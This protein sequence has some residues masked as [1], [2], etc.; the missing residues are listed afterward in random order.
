MNEVTNR[1][2]AYSVRTYNIIDMGLTFSAMIRL[3]SKGSKE[4]I[5]EKIVEDIAKVF[6]VDSKQEYDEVHASFCLWGNKNIVL[7]KRERNGKIIKKAGPAS[8]GQ[9]AKTFDVV[10]KVAIYYSHLPECESAQKIA[11]YLNA[12]LDD[13]MMN[14]LK[15]HYPND[16]NPWP[17]YVEDV[18]KDTY[19]KLQMLVKKFIIDKHDNEIMSVQFDDIY[20]KFLNR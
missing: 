15:K 17:K 14:M 12:A 13:P 11:P 8:Y 2:D 20:W 16:I 3:F 1:Q 7:A 4:N 9:M 6:K 18:D 10:M 5:H 19:I